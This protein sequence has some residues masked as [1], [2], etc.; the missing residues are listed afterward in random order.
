VR[1][2]SEQGGKLLLNDPFGHSGFESDGLPVAVKEGLLEVT[3]NPGE[4]VVL[5]GK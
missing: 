5:T 4:K 2:F 3:F 1:L